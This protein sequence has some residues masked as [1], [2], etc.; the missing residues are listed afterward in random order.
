[1]IW[2]N[3]NLKY[4]ILYSALYTKFHQHQSLGSGEDFFQMFFTINGY[5]GHLIYGY[6]QAMHETDQNTY[7][8]PTK[9]FPHTNAQENKFD[10]SIKRPK[11]NLGS[12]LNK[13]GHL[14]QWQVLPYRFQCHLQFGSSLKKILKVCTIYG[15]DSHLGHMTRPLWINFHYPI[16]GDYLW[17][18]ALAL[19]EKI[20]SFVYIIIKVHEP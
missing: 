15:H 4:L 17:N 19:G 2:E 14:L 7:I 3:Q 20:L 9:K 12:L 8:G 6:K 10:L 18:L 5:G 11:I 13:L 1:M 16:P